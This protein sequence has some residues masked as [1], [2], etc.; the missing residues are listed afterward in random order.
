MSIVQSQSTSNPSSI[1]QF[2]SIAAL[3]GDQSCVRE[4]NREYR[5]RH[6]YLIAE[7][8]SLPGISCLRGAGT[9]YAFAKVEDARRN[10]GLRDD[11]AF[12]EHLLNAGV[13]VVPGS[14]FGA[15]DHMR[16]S[17]ACSLQM[18]QK[19]VARIAEA[20]RMPTAKAT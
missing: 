3:N 18:L 11:I 17:F 16:L 2:A 7:L 1:A 20:L 19:A 12:A 13:A 10:L 14:A 9:F 5:A 8:N 15:S 6:D 4:M